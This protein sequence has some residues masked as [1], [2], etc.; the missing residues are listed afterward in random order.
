RA[1][2]L[3]RDVAIR[4]E[5]A[6]GRSA[7]L[8]VA[9]VLARKDV[10]DEACC[11]ITVF[12]LHEGAATANLDVVAMRTET[13]DDSGGRQIWLEGQHKAYGSQSVEKPGFRNR[14]DELAAP[15]AYE[16]H[17]AGDFL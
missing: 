7:R 1:K 9:S 8:G 13:E 2:L 5:H 11:R 15:L 10:P 3:Y 17:L 6:G 16:G 4:S 12:E 14:H